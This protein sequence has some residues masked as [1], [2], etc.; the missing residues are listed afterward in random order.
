MTL[1]SILNWSIL[2]PSKY[3]Q[4]IFSEDAP[5]EKMCLTKLAVLVLKDED[6]I[7]PKRFFPLVLRKPNKVRDF[8]SAVLLNL[9]LHMLSIIWLISFLLIK[10]RK[11]KITVF[12]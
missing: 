4:I 7:F 3:W 11:E 1:D 5:F 8:E 10:G 6:M 9:A 2:V 12:L